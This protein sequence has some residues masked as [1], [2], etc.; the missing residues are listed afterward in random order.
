LRAKN[1]N[2]GLQAAATSKMRLTNNREAI[3]ATPR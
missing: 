3:S 2:G 1:K